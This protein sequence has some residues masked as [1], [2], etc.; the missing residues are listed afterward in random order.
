MS[1]SPQSSRL[2]SLIAG[3]SSAGNVCADVQTLAARTSMDTEAVRSAVA[4]LVTDGLVTRELAG[5]TPRAAAGV[6]YRL[7]FAGWDLVDDMAAVDPRADLDAKQREYS[8]AAAVV[9]RFT[10]FSDATHR[11]SAAAIAGDD[12]AEAVEAEELAKRRYDRALTRYLQHQRLAG[13]AR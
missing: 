10:D 4:V 9:S 12:F 3:L 8:Q 11:G 7:T 2:L 13:V 5:T 6:E 1:L